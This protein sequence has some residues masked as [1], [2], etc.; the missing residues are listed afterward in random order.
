MKIIESITSPDGLLNLQV[1]ES[2]DGSIA[3]GFI[4]GDWHT[5][6]DLIASWLGVNEDKAI[7]EFLN[8]ITHDKFPIITSIDGGVTFD[9]WV[10][11]NH[12]A[13]VKCYGEK[14]CVVR[15]WSSEPLTHPS[16]GTMD[17]SR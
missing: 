12:V 9:P 14:D 16:S 8:Q 7:E 13:S 3:V 6:P 11:D 4:G 1:Q 17:L 10:S 15:F 2:D 5:H